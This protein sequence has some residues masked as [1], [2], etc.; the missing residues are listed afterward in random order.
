MQIFDVQLS[1]FKYFYLILKIH[2]QS[3]VDMNVFCGVI[4]SKL[5]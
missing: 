1:W 4:E 5:D 2:A 3:H